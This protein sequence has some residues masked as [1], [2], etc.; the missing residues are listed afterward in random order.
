MKR[1]LVF[2]FFLQAAAA[3]QGNQQ[4]AAEDRGHASRHQ[5]RAFLPAPLE[6]DRQGVGRGAQEAPQE[7]L[8]QSVHDIDAGFDP[9]HPD[10][11]EAFK[12]PA[13]PGRSNVPP[14]GD[15]AVAP[16]K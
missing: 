11:P 2:L 7:L 16:A 9:A 1:V 4:Q 14:R 12:L 3:Q 10:P 8:A 5:A 15:P 13:S 6:Y